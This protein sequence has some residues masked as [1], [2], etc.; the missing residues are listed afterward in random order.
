MVVDRWPE[1]GDP[2]I[3]NSW[4]VQGECAA[5]G[6]EMDLLIA[7]IGQRREE[8]WHSPW[9]RG[10]LHPVNQVLRFQ[11]RDGEPFGSTWERI[12]REHFKGDRQDW[13]DALTE[14]GLL[15]EILLVHQV[16]VPEH[17]PEIRELAQKK[18][19]R[20]Q[21]TVELPEPQLSQCFSP[22]HPCQFKSCC[23]YWRLPSE[24]SGFLRLPPEP[25][26]LL[27]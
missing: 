12:W 15:P 13:L 4:D 20:I 22:I 23:P 1:L 3:L 25:R 19:Q 18:L 11:K 2:A 7:V 5:Y 24:K 6:I 10:V 16:P 8:R 26:P 17:A 14:D 21:N 27:P 9:T